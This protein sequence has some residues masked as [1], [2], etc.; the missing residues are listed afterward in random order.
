[1]TYFFRIFFKYH[2]GWK[3]NRCLIK[4]QLRPWHHSFISIS[5]SL[6]LTGSVHFKKVVCPELDYGSQHKACMALKE[7][8]PSLLPARPHWASYPQSS[9]IQQDSV[10]GSL[11][12]CK[13]TFCAMGAGLTALIYNQ[14]RRGKGRKGA[15]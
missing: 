8:Q 2:L 15:F 13:G 14:E 11:H 3:S 10:L 4:C 1:M 7:P 5:N 9:D 12:N 6:S